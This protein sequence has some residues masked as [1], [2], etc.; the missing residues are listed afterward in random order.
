MSKNVPTFEVPMIF[1]E[2]SRSKIKEIKS[3]SMKKYRDETGLFIAQGDKCVADTIKSFGQAYLVCTG[4]WY[5]AHS[6][7][8]KDF[9]GDIYIAN[10]RD[11]DTISTLK[12]APDVIAVLKIPSESDEIPALDP[13]KFY[14]LLDEIQDP[15]NLGTI[16][17]TCDWFGVYDI[18][19]SQDTVDVFSPKVVQST[20]GSL[21]RV[22]VKYLD[23][24]KLIDNNSSINVFGTLLAG[25]PISDMAS[26]E[27]GM[28]LMGNEGKGISNHLKTKIDVPLTIPP[29]NTEAHPDSLN[30]AIATAIV[31]SDL[32]SKSL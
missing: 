7:L 6:D 24:E 9:S 4:A 3:L 31:L 18:F 22:K 30:V 8:V 15:G 23:L 29:V 19:A 11:L 5:D 21:S 12:S 20:M 27:G 32:T 17:R 16:I 14:L 1:K 2:L 10:H 13:K 26:P 25:L 28:I